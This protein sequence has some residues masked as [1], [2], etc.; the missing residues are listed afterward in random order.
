MSPNDMVINLSIILILKFAR[1]KD[2]RALGIK[3]FDV[4]PNLKFLRLQQICG[5]LTKGKISFISECNEAGCNQVKVQNNDE[6][7]IC[8]IR[9]ERIKAHLEPVRCRKAE[10]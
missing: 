2:K 6:K 10:A 1:Y 5:G 3:D 9:L 4:E 8:N 7:Q